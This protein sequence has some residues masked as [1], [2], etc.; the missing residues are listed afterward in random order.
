V[1][2]MPWELWNIID[3]YASVGKGERGEGRGG[4]PLV[5]GERMKG[6]PLK[7]GPAKRGPRKML[8]EGES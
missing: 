4:D 1:K 5:Y 6:L 7:R 2:I 8:E 3:I